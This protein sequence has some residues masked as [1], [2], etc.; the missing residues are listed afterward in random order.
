VAILSDIIINE[1][2][3]L[4]HTNYLVQ[5][6][7]ICLIFLL[8]HIALVTELMARA[9]TLCIMPPNICGS[10]VCKSL[11]VTCLMLRIL[12]WL[13]TK[14]FVNPCSNTTM[15][16]EFIAPKDSSSSSSVTNQQHLNVK[17]PPKSCYS[18]LS[19]QQN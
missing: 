15:L 17:R 12:R 3:K 10:L 6:V 1:N 14:I 5:K 2:L 4:L 11:H 9:S 18:A 19:T 16:T 13:L 8:G 7:D